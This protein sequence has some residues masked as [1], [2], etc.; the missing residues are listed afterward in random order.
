VK[1]NAYL[2]KSTIV[3]ALGGLL[4][5]FDTAVIAGTTRDL[6]RTIA[7]RGDRRPDGRKRALGHILGRCS[8][9]IPATA[10]DRRDS[11]AVW[12][13][14]ICFRDRLRPG[15]DMVVLVFSASWKGLHRRS[16]VLG[17]MYI[18]EICAGEMARPAG[19]MLSISTWCSRPARY[20][21]N[22]VIGLMHFWRHRVGAGSLA[23]PLSLRR[24]SY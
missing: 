18:A 4:L 11:R 2:A 15:L 16:S 12:L 22:Y 9:G 13:C 24:F 8:A 7:C 3:A 17:P 1:L 6:T 14:S 5:G 19:G 20:F 23:F 10:T 21:S